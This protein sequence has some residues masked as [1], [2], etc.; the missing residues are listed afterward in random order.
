MSAMSVKCQ[1]RFDAAC[2]YN[3][4]THW[5]QLSF[6]DYQQFHLSAVWIVTKQQ[7]QNNV[8]NNFQNCNNNNS[9]CK[10]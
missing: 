9:M 7:I 8:S 10:W 2:S 6:L 3:S 5:L 1:I 4:E